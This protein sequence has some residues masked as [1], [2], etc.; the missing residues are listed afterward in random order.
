MV[1][2]KTK[3]ISLSVIL[4]YYCMPHTTGLLEISLR[5]K[6]PEILLD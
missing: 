3:Y 4:E 2:G 6:V 5:L 1:V